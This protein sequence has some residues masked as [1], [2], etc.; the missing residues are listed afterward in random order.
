MAADYGVSRSE[1][2][3]AMIAAHEA[4]Q[5]LIEFLHQKQ[6]EP[7]MPEERQRRMIAPPTSARRQSKGRQNIRPYSIKPSSFW[8]PEPSE[9]LARDRDLQK[10]SLS[11]E[12]PR[13][14]LLAAP[15]TNIST[16]TATE[17]ALTPTAS[18]RWTKINLSDGL[19][20]KHGVR[21]AW[22]HAIL[23]SQH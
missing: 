12:K 2:V 1:A 15:P 11:P 6:G 4:W 7:K 17:V 13:T 14:L 21:Q 16:P 22:W 9:Q 10:S 23:A 5:L 19:L 3:R 8:R 20:Q 18:Q